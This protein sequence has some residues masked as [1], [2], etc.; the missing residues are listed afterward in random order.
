MIRIRLVNEQSAI[1]PS[2]E[3]LCKGM[4]FSAFSLK[5]SV[6]RRERVYGIQ[7]AL[8]VENFPAKRKASISMDRCSVTLFAKVGQPITYQGC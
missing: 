3:S 2:G 6:A 7:N 8:T 5:G 4:R 1:T